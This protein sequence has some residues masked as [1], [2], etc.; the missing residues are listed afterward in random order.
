MFYRFVLLFLILGFSSCSHINFASKRRNDLGLQASPQEKV[1]INLKV[2]K[3]VLDNGLKVLLVENHKLPIYS[4]YTYFQVGSKFEEKGITG[5]S[6]FLEH[7]MFKGAKKYGPGEFDKV[8]EGNGGSNN[9]YTTRDHTVYYENMPAETIKTVI[10]LEADRMVN[11]LLI[12]QAFEA[13]KRVVLEERRYRYENKP[14]GQLML[15]VMDEVFTKT[16]YGR[17]VIGDIPDL[18][19]VSRDQIM[20]Y[21][22][23]FYAPNSATI[24]VVGD[25]D[26]DKVLEEI[27]EKYGPIPRSKKFDE[28][29]H[30]KDQE[31]L[32]HHRAEYRRYIDINGQAPNPMFLIAFRGDPLGTERSYI[33]DILGS[34]LGDGN[35]S[36]FQQKYVSGKSPILNSLYVGNYNLKNNG[37]F[38]IGG[39]LL[40]GKSLNEFKKRVKKDFKK[41]CDKAITPRAVQKT[42]NQYM[43]QYY[44]QLETNAG[45]AGFIGSR[46][47]FLDDYEVYKKELETYQ[48][49]SVSQVKK[50]CHDIF[51]RGDYIMTS[52]WNKNPKKKVRSF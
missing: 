23:T 10:D 49:M 7:M 51:D 21:F 17:S 6:H 30:N 32:Y 15:A 35:S 38:L 43:V 8:V 40:G 25:I 41:V 29:F 48:A 11:L 34:V 3:E 36:Y 47:A 26:S 20:E 50:V 1:S 14:R 42:K 44:Q 9:A 52:V 13:E 12:E 22:K 18:K 46:E 24:V 37:V 27:K 4:Y 45:V 19:S 2:R 16:P 33:M 5:A 28:I 31:Y 39:E